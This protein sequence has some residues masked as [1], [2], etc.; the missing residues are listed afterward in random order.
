MSGTSRT[1]SGLSVRVLLQEGERS[2]KEAAVESPRREAEWLLSQFLGLSRMELYLL[3]E[4]VPEALSAAYRS[5]LHQRSQGKPLQYLTGEA[6]F[7]GEDFF[8]APGVFIPRPETEA[9]VEALLGPLSALQRKAGRALRILDAGSGSGCIAVTLARELPA[10]VVVGVELSWNALRCARQNAGRH[11]LTSRLQWVQGRWLSAIGG[12]FDAIV[13]NPP[14][15][16]SGQVARLPLDVRQEPRES[17]DGG[18]DGLDPYR[19]LVVEAKQRLAP[20]GLLAFE[21]G[22]EQV[23]P[24]RL[25]LQ[26]TGWISRI[27]T[28]QDLTR[29]PRGVIAKRASNQTSKINH[30]KQERPYSEL[31]SSL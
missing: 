10:C 3:D 9:V 1:R 7:H 2:L 29:R 6:P 14:Y 28:I 11:G 25:L 12:T 26:D 22:E 13:A 16:S 23:S 21:C 19:V 24:I 8:V 5:Q 31:N 20:E 4:P 18:T 27:E 17:L 30:Q 15:I